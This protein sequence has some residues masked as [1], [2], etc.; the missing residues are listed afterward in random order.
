M[1]D[2]LYILNLLHAYFTV[3]DIDNVIDKGNDT[4][5]KKYITSTDPSFKFETPTKSSFTTSD[6]RNILLHCT[7]EIRK[8]HNTVE[9]IT[10]VTEILLEFKTFIDTQL[11][12]DPTLSSMN[13]Q[14]F[15]D[16][17]KDFRD[18]ETL[19][20][21]KYKTVERN[22]SLEGGKTRKRLYKRKTQ[23]K[24]I[25]KRKTHYKQKRRTF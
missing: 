24:K 10:R 22:L 19:I 9:H 13:I 14:Q 3:I 16:E 12:V 23:R 25:H 1:D 11:E 7:R 2:Q 18:N 17:I 4:N 8:T 5:F 15:C 20:P 6:L 21:D